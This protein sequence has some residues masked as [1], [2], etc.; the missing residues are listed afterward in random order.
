MR[1]KYANFH[2]NTKTPEL[3]NPKKTVTRIL[4]NIDETL[5]F[6]RNKLNNPKKTVTRIMTHID[7]TLA[8]YRN[9]CISNGPGSDDA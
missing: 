9:I 4:T 7:E 5:A 1:S 2:R 6:Y 8:F 3:N